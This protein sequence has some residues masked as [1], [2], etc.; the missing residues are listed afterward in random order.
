MLLRTIFLLAL[1]AVTA[2]TI[3]HGAASLAQAALRQRALDAART[4][5]VTGVGSARSALA[6]GRTPAPVATCAYA[7][8]NGCELNLQ[9]TFATPTPAAAPAPS[10][11]PGTPCT[12]MLQ[13]NTA[14]SEGRAAFIITAAVSAASGAP[15]A[16]RSAIVTFRTF[17][18]APFAS[19]VG[20]TDAS[21]S[22]LLNGGSGDDAGAPNTLITVEYDQSGNGTATSGNV[23]Q[24]IVESPASAA[25]AWER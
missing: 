22:A 25:P 10:A 4:G 14:V 23:W 3:V 7:D 5:I 12:V 20:G 2:E 9:T 19:I 15:L 17:A 11:C 18:A 8:A 16:T 6:S 24:P 21:L 13:D 1:L